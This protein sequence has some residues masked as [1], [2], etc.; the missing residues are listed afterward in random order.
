[1]VTDIT[2]SS[3][4]R[5]LCRGL[6]FRENVKHIVGHSS[7][8]RQVWSY[9]FIS[10]LF[11]TKEIGI[12]QCKSTACKNRAHIEKRRGPLGTSLT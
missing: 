9:Q 1:M 12:T 11:I 10:K 7:A 8:F 4:L 2:S 5:S 3:I 6:L